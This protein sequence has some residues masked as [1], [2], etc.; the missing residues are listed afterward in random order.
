M[1]AS[2]AASD[3]FSERVILVTGAGQGLGRAAALALAARGATVILLGRT[4]ARLERVYDEIVA[5]G[6]PM[7]AILP[8]DLAAAADRDFETLA[9]SIAVQLGRLD[10]ILHCAAHFT[11]L[12]P[13]SLQT[14]EQWQT[15]FKVNAIAPFAINRACEPLLKR[16]P[17]AAVVLVGETHGH[18][19]AAYWGGF[20]VSKAAQEAYFRVLADEWAGLTNLHAH[21]AIPGPVN[22]P[23]RN[24]TH[25]AEDKESLPSP[26]ALAAWLVEL[27]GPAGRAVRGQIVEYAAAPRREA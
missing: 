6:G 17:D 26:Q 5:A 14:V 4:V 11:S 3:P 13:L 20:A 15:L 24:R 10:G 9:Q 23:Q 19:P 25:P 8:V 18:A 7:P 22:T 16:S 21:L 2:P 1:N 27:M 12:S